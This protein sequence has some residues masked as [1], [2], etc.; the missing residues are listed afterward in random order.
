MLDQATPDQVEGPRARSRRLRAQ[1]AA[2]GLSASTRLVQPRPREDEATWNDR[3]EFGLELRHGSGGASETEHAM[4]SAWLIA[5]EEPSKASVSCDATD[6]RAWDSRGSRL[7]CYLGAVRGTWQ[8]LS[9]AWRACVE[10]AWSAFCDGSRPIGAVIADPDGAVVARGRNTTW[11]EGPDGHRERGRLEHAELLTLMS[12]DY[13]ALD[14]ATLTLYSTTEPCPMCIGALRV[15]GVREVRYARAEA[16]SGAVNLLDAS[17]YMRRAAIRVVRPNVPA[18]ERLL[19]ALHV[20]F[21]LEVQP[22]RARDVLESW[23]RADPVAVSAGE[24]LAAAGVLV[25]LRRRAVSAEEAVA[26][27]DPYL[28]V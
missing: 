13:A 6:R 18:L 22:V 2:L 24:R 25:D 27:I 26:A 8:A 3:R 19:I 12:L 7:P 20:A 5:T 15:S 14:P 9:P 23:K 11:R 28:A 17:D 21:S 16:W 10:E 4:P 1:A